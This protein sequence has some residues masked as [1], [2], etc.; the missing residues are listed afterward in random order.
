MTTPQEA[1]L[2]LER[3]LLDAVDM[4]EADLGLLRSPRI[5]RLQQRL[6]ELAERF[7]AQSTTETGDDP[8]AT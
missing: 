6:C 3:A 1:D 7:A 2:I 4:I 8:R 5:A